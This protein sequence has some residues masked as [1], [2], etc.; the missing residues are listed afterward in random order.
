MNKTRRALDEFYI[1]GFPTNIP[2]HREVVKDKDF[3]EGTFNTGYLDEKMETFDFSV[4]SPIEKML[5]QKKN[6]NNKVAAIIGAI[7]KFQEAK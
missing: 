2:L 7:C 6:N 1:G 4:K 5:A 3:Q